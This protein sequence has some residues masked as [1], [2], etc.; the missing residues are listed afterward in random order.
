MSGWSTMLGGLLIWLLHFGLVYAVPSLDAI[1]AMKPQ[2]LYLL[3]DLS[4]VGCF[5]VVLALTVVCWRRAT[6]TPPETAF[7]DRLGA[8]GAAI[9]AVAILFQATPD[10]IA[11]V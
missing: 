5:G 2:A 10:W 11:R 9:A 4:T 8:L 3:H 6:K 7:R 1:R